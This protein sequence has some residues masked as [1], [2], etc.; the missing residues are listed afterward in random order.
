MKVIDTERLP[1]KLWLEDIEE[2]AGESGKVKEGTL[3]SEA[4]CTR[5]ESSG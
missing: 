2:G 5:K 1:I 4:G 3:C